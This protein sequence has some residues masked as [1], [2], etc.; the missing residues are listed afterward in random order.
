MQLFMLWTP[1]TEENKQIRG[2]TMQLAKWGKVLA[3]SAAV[4]LFAIPASAQDD[5]EGPMTQGDDAHY[6]S[7]TV[8]K[9][10]PG[11]RERAFEIIADHFM[12]AG[13]KAGTPGPLGTIHFQTGEWDALF[14]WELEGGMADLEWYRSANNIKWY[15]ALAEQEGGK[16]AAGELMAEYRSLI[17]EAE[18]DVGHYHATKEGDDE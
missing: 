8:V 9:F 5:E 11:K 15:A 17:D 1:A 6:V 16:E 13:E 10:K 14:V 2:Y 3:V 4:T 18:T 7:T 12:P